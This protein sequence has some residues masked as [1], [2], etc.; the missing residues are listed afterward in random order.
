MVEVYY[1]F[2]YVE[3]HLPVALH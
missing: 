2:K 1:P 3:K